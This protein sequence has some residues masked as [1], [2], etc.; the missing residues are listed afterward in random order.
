[1][2]SELLATAISATVIVGSLCYWLYKYYRRKKAMQKLMQ[3]FMRDYFLM[4]WDYMEA[5]KT[6]LRKACQKN[7]KSELHNED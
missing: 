7:A 5:H 2:T 4:E 1:M 3:R 6:M